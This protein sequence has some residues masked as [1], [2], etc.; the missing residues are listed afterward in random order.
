[1]KH[2]DAAILK[3]QI[4][5]TAHRERPASVADLARHSR[6]ESRTFLRRFSKATG[7]K[8]KEYQQR[9]QI[10]RAREMLEFSCTG[11]DEI[12]SRVGYIDID[13]F[14]RVFRKITGLAP[15]DYRRRFA[16]PNPSKSGLATRATRT[17]NGVVP[18][19][20]VVK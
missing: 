10:S 15:S 4:W 2:G 6:L 7:L 11:I 19:L 1:M 14:R 5:L 17:D 9:L 3:A 18:V 8:P 12:A 13:A 16:R 20:A